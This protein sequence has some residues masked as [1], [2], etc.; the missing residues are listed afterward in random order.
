METVA[1]LGDMYQAGTLS[2]NPIAMACGI[3]TLKE[4]KKQD[5]YDSR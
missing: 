3:A 1:P 4:L 5:P 2:G